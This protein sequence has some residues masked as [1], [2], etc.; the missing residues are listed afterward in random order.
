MNRTFFLSVVASFAFA[1]GGT[2]TTT[3]S[4]AGSQL[5]DAGGCAGLDAE[6]A[7]QAPTSIY[8]SYALEGCRLAYVASGSQR[9]VLRDLKT[10][11][12][13]FVTD[14]PATP[15]DEPRR[16][17][18][19]DG[20]VAWE[21][22]PAP[23]SAVMVATSAGTK[24]LVGEFDHA[25]EP[26]AFGGAVVFTGWKSADPL[27]DT[28]VFLWDASTGT[29]SAIATGP[30]QQRFADVNA[31][32]V[33]Y[34]DFA[35]DPDGRFDQNDTDL[36]DIVLFDRATK[37]ATPR[38]LA[39]KQ[40]FPV[41]VSDDRFGYVHWGDVHPE[42]KFQA[43]GIRGARIGTEPALDVVVADVTSAT[44]FWLPS[45]SGGTIDWIAPETAGGVDVL[46]RAPVDGQQVKRTVLDGTLVGPPQ[47]S[48]TL[49]LVALQS[50][51]TVGLKTV[52]R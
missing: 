41:L 50:N 34:T 10:G 38:K 48:P 15:A 7:V 42:P 21:T 31:K 20:F 45:G 14:V 2:A 3:P 51:G 39:G 46:W 40:A 49:T 33:A 13:S 22:G 19:G 25:G 17:T 44:R 4:D 29:V 5:P 47:S 37:K 27:G 36:A 52:D 18:L 8:P 6:V 23:A 28:D 16:P 35:E 1:C 26:R 43:F 11:T 32:H 9:L 12:E 24:K 30:A